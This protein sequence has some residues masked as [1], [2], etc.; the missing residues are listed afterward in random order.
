M[1]RYN[2]RFVAIAAVARLASGVERRMTNA[3]LATAFGASGAT[4]ARWQKSYPE[5]C[6]A[7]RSNDHDELAA[8]RNEFL[9]WQPEPEKLKRKTRAERLFEA[10]NVSLDEAKRVASYGR[11]KRRRALARLRPRPADNLKLQA[12]RRSAFN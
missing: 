10:Y 5:F 4:I 1:T 2:K 6:D 11:T 12:K 9:N 8:L 7:C 3:D